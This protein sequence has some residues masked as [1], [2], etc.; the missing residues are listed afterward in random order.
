M[1]HGGQ[2]L[3][4]ELPWPPSVNH[5]WR[6][7]RNGHYISLE[8]QTYRETVFFMCSKFRKLIP[9]DAR[10]SLRIEAFPPDRRKRDLDN[11]LKSLLDALQKAE[12][13][14]DDGQID[15]ISISRKTPLNGKVQITIEK[16]QNGHSSSE[17]S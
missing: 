7:T 16:I 5:Y 15:H 14:G 4:I 6:H 9:D 17:K 2:M 8:G 11:V 3:Q 13:Y 10:L 1:P 12:V